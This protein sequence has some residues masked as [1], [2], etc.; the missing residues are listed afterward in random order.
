MVD[1]TT[2]GGVFDLDFVAGEV[3]D[4]TPEGVLLSEGKAESGTT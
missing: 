4:L 1:P 3:T 2:V